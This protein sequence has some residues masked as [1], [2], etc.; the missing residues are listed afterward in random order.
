M[1]NERKADYDKTW[2]EILAKAQSDEAFRKRLIENPK[3]VAADHG[4]SIPPR[5]DIRVVEN[6]STVVRIVLTATQMQ[7]VLSDEQLDAVAGGTGGT[8]FTASLYKE[9]S[10]DADS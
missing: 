10:L 4:I 7:G 6:A 2:R 9:Y 1:T 5:V 3:S 8:D